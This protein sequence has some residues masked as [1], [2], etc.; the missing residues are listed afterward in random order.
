MDV[1]R[2]LIKRQSEEAPDVDHAVNQAAARMS[3]LLTA[4]GV[5]AATG[6]YV[7]SDG[8]NALNVNKAEAVAPEAAAPTGPKI[9]HFDLDYVEGEGYG[10]TAADD[11]AS[12]AEVTLQSTR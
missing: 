4:D 1:S 12:V 10:F 2:G 8:R 7:D 5:S 11:G 9:V 6:A 3:C